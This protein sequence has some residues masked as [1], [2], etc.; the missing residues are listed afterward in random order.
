MRLVRH[1]RNH[2]YRIKLKDLPG[3]DRLTTDPA[4]LE[5]EFK[6]CACGLSKNKPFCD[7]SHHI[8]KKEEDGKLYVYD[9]SNTAVRID[10]SY[11]G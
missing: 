8:A 7:S 1:D 6:I 3:I 2:S 9:A 11:E 5:Y 10:D 4:L